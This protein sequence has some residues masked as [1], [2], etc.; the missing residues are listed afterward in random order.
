MSTRVMGWPGKANARKAGRSPLA[1]SHLRVDIEDLMAEYTLRHEFRNDGPDSIEATFSFPTPL[2]AAFLGMEAVLAGERRRATVMPAG[3]AT[4]TYDDAIADGDSAVLLEQVEKGMLNVSLGNLAPGEVG[5]VTLRFAAMLGVAGGQARFTLPLVHRPR[6][7]IY[8]QVEWQVP[9]HDFAVEH[10]LEAEVRVRGLLAQVPVTCGTPGATF[11]LA[12]GELTLTLTRAMLDRDLVLA[13]QIDAEIATSARQ[14]RDEDA[15]IGI[16][17]YLA[18]KTPGT[19]RLPLNLCLLMDCSGSMAGDAI[20]QSRDALHAVS[21]ALTE[22]DRLQ[23]IRFGTELKP[24][25]R[26]PLNASP[27]VLQAMEAIASSMEADLGGT[28]MGSALEE[29]LASLSASR[30]EGEQSVV[31][32][33]TDGAVQ[34]SE[35]RAA[36]QRA[37]RDGVRIFI[38]AVGSS[39]GTDVLLPLAVKTGGVLER[40]VPAEPIHDGV[41]RQL[42]RA[43]CARPAPIQVAW[44]DGSAQ[45]VAA[46]SVYPGDAGVAVA[47]L[48]TPA[49]PESEARVSEG[50]DVYSAPMGETA[51]S[52]AWRAWAGQQAYGAASGRGRERIALRY[53]LITP[54]T[55]AVL[56]KVRAGEDKLDGLPE[57]V[58]VPHMVPDGML[59]VPP[60]GIAMSMRRSLD[61]APLICASCGDGGGSRALDVAAFLDGETNEVEPDEPAPLIGRERVIAE[62]LVARALVALLIDGPARPADAPFEWEELLDHVPG[63]SHEL[64]IRFIRLHGPPGTKV[65]DAM[66]VLDSLLWEN[67]AIALSEEHEVELAKRYAAG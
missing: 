32:L 23:V 49:S 22:D 48:A 20:A 1:E 53:G 30:N 54:E 38:V 26:R 35:V 52:P 50:S 46:V 58:V 11:R 16:L 60:A 14:V 8:R 67:H 36:E 19:P 39:A 27:R 15:A 55:S 63:E 43:R 57:T 65:R 51:D 17:T 4:R 31:V 18:P 7:G 45:Q 37:Q 33:V 64:V 40:A 61:R 12:E 5:E 34:P 29:A 62:E 9:K 6:Y 21:E 59:A 44:P 10:P 47:M 56:V 3:K 41:T 2:D 66:A 42:A 13:F 24:M 28:E 25:F